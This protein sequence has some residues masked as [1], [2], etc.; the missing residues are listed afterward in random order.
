MV[1]TTTDEVK[2][3]IPVRMLHVA[4]ACADDPGKYML[5]CVMVESRPNNTV[6]TIG[7]DGR[8]LIV[9]ETTAGLFDG[10]GSILMPADIAMAV[11]RLAKP[12]TESEQDEPL[13]EISQVDCQCSVRV[14]GGSGDVVF[15]WERIDGQFPPYREAIPDWMVSIGTSYIGITPELVAS[16]LRALEKISGMDSVRV[17]LPPSSDKPIGFE[18]SSNDLHISTLAVVMPKNIEGWRPQKI[19]AEKKPSAAAET[20]TQAA[21]PQMTID[22]E[23]A[24]K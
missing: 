1:K 15:D 5:N 3:E 24:P 2:V 21:D 16:S 18:S 12:K 17:F 13:A 9:A 14:F 4:Q 19:K 11:V 23:I 22:Q 20:E 10:Q 7:T 8:R 6:A